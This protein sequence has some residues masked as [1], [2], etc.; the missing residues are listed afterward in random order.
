MKLNQ[1]KYSILI[2]LAFLLSLT[3]KCTTTSPLAGGTENGE[4][5]I[6]G[7]IYNMDETTPASGAVVTLLPADQKPLDS[8]QVVFVDTADKQGNFLF[9]IPGKIYNGIAFN[10]FA[11]L[12]GKVSFRNSIVA[13]TDSTVIVPTVSL[14]NPGSISGKIQ[15]MGTDDARRIRISVIGSQIAV[16]CSDSMGTFR[17]DSLAQGTYAVNISDTLNGY[18]PYDTIIAVSAGI[19]TVI[20]QSII[21]TPVTFLLDNFDDGDGFSLANSVLTNSAWYAWNDSING[22]KSTVTPASVI[23]N[24]ATCITDVGAYRGK[25]VHCTFVLDKVYPTPSE[26]FTCVLAPQNG[27]VD[28]TQLKSVSFYI[29]GKDSVRVSF[30]SKK[31]SDFPAGRNWGQ[32]GAVV[33]CPPTWQKVTVPVSLLKPQPYSVQDSLHMTWNM[34]RDSVDRLVFGTEGARGD[35]VDV[36][37]DNITFEGMP[38]S[39]FK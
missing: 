25:S 37:L 7:V 26:G 28:F 8:T 19:V 18:V 16:S 20:S 38:A 29:Q 12:Q 15:L 27:Y 34:V 36:W 3:A 39:S 33:A 35:T 14:L 17:L 21:L 24:F 22:G 6:A 30:T 10:C 1:I 23:S 11:K 13:R 4:A 2:G 32:L 5:K 9:A 31:V